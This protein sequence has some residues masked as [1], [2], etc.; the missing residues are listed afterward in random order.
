MLVYLGQPVGEVVSLVVDGMGEGELHEVELGEDL[1]HGWDDELTE[2]VVVVDMQ[3]TSTY[4]VVAEVL[5]LLGGEDDVAVAGHVDEGVVEQF[6][7]AHVDN[8]VLCGEVHLG[9]GV[10]EGYEVGE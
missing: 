6:G 2:A 5:R 10:A 7:T 3:E 1:F 8:G 4:E 9:I